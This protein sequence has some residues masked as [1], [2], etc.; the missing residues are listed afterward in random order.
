M[1]CGRTREVL[2]AARVEVGELRQAKKS[3]LGEKE[4]SALIAS[5]DEVLVVRGKNVVTIAARD[6][7]VADLRGPTGN[8]RA[9]LLRFGRRLLVGFSDAALRAE[10][11][12]R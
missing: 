12:R 7:S 8:V 10:L 6:A 4:V 11:G 5:V 3:P 1:S 2:D 9:P